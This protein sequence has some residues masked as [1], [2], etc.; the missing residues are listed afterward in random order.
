MSREINPFGL[1]MP[2]ELKDKIQRQAENN[3]RSMNA[4]IIARLESSF[5]FEEPKSEFTE[6]FEMLHLFSTMERV[7]TEQGDPDAV[8]LLKKVSNNKNFYSER[9][10][11]RIS[12][13][14]A[15][16]LTKEIFKD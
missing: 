10:S 4:E 13:M 2:I 1:R 5:T 11:E 8:D 9:I 6:L 16:E 14:S 7:L 3:G 15:E 12:S